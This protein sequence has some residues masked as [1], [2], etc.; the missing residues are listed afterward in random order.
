MGPIHKRLIGTWKSHKRKTLATYKAYDSLPRARK[1]A[2]GVIFGR[3]E[4]RYTQKFYYLTLN[5]QTTRDHYDVIGEDAD[6]IV[7][8]TY[9]DELRKKVD[10]IVLEVCDDLFE[11]RIQHLHFETERQQDYY[12]IGVRVLVEWFKKKHPGA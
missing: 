3:L 4:L 5:G 10:P 11:P 6:S 9:S 2:F 12:W 7:L 8:M 1:R